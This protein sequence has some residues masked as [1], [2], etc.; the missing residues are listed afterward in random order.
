MDARKVE[1]ITIIKKFKEMK[2]DGCI[3]TYTPWEK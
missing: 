2:A 1:F 3:N